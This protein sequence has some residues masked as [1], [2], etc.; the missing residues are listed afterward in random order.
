MLKTK[1]NWMGINTIESKGYVC[2]YCGHPLASDKGYS[3]QEIGYANQYPLITI[4]HF[5]T[6]PT[7]FDR[8]TGKQWPGAA[9]GNEVANVDDDLVEA[10]YNEA[11]AC[12]ATSSYT[13]A[14]MCC[15]KL[16]M[17]IAV[18]LGAEEN[19]KF[20]FY[21]DYLADNNYIPPGAKAWVTQIKD[22]GNE[23][24][25]EIKLMSQDDAE[26]LISFSEMLLK[27][28]YEFPARIRPKG[29]ST[30]SSAPIAGT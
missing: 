24:N 13:A 5:C 29:T 11:R 12:T 18:S 9:F 10:L 8:E 27:V 14:V 21:V 17:H 20:Y 22:K 16:L 26:E 23:A 30:P 7:F 2:G 3:A 15:R 28:I 25:H 4:C 6:R 19:K 1:Y